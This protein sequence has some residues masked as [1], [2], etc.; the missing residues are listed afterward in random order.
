MQDEAALRLHGS[1][2]HHGLLNLRVVVAVQG[3]LL[4]YVRDVHIQRPVD[5]DAQRAGVAVL[6]YVSDGV[7]EIRVRHARHGYQQLPC[8]CMQ[9]IHSVVLPS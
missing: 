7:L 5:H 2:A 6:T 3:E 9:I 4:K 1:A 8:E